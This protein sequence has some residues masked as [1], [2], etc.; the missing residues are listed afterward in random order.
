MADA[1]AFH[2]G[3][4]V[5]RAG[6]ENTDDDAGFTRPRALVRVLCITGLGRCHQ[7]QAG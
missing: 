6:L 5:E 2:V 1:N 4:G 7:Q 3:D